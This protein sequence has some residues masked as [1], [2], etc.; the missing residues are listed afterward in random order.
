M[1][2]RTK[3][4]EEEDFYDKEAKI[5]EDKIKNQMKVLEKELNKLN[6]INNQNHN[7]ALK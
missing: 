1:L 4:D 7:A 5:M 6:N 3:L 2:F